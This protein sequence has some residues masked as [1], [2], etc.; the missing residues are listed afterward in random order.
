MHSKKMY[1]RRIYINHSRQWF[2]NYARQRPPRWWGSARSRK[3]NRS[4]YSERKK[5]KLLR[6]LLY[7]EYKKWNRKVQK[8][9]ITEIVC[10]FLS[11][12]FHTYNRF[13][14]FYF[15]TAKCNK[16]QIFF[17]HRIFRLQED[18]FTR[19]PKPYGTFECKRNAKNIVVRSGN[20]VSFAIFLHALTTTRKL[21]VT[22]WNV[23]VFQLVL[24][25]E[26][27]TIRAISV[28]VGTS[29]S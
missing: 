12:F 17:S 28:F 25:W 4:V 11:T 20:P 27:Q 19:K 13:I 6:V 8:I 14:N 5:K 18:G 10:T 15:A 9:R 21:R 23:F 24:P 29:L 3:K 26:W 16:K 1:T 2:S 22:C 7:R